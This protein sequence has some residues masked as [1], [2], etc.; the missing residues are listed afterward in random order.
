M[1]QQTTNIFNILIRYYSIQFFV[2]SFYLFLLLLLLPPFPN[3]SSSLW[4]MNALFCSCTWLSIKTWTK[5]IIHWIIHPIAYTFSVFFKWIKSDSTPMCCNEMSLVLCWVFGLLNFK[6]I[7]SLRKL[8]WFIFRYKNSYSFSIYLS[9]IFNGRIEA[10]ETG[11]FLISLA[12]WYV[13]Y[14]KQNDFNV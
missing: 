4:A 12:I 14:G 3:F 9:F 11:M 2:L 6:I 13:I 8:I 7:L 10:L 5:W 1:Y